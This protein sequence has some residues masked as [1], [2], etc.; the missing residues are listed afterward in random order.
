MFEFVRISG[1]VL[2]HYFLKRS[3]NVSRKLNF[4]TL[5]PDQGVGIVSF[6][7]I[8][9]FSKIS[10]RFFSQFCTSSTFLSVTRQLL[11]FVL[12]DNYY[13]TFYLSIS[14]FFPDYILPRIRRQI[15]LTFRDSVVTSAG[16]CNYRKRYGALRSNLNYR[17]V[18]SI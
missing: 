10:A 7:N 2:V 5:S 13:V 6:R 8:F 15:P 11:R 16:R 1:G 18:L 12:L 3:Q 9:R 17:Q 4:E 14:L